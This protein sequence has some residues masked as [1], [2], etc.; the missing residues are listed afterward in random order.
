MPA[1]RSMFNSVD[2]PT[3]GIPRTSTFNSMACGYRVPMS[4]KSSRRLEMNVRR[5]IRGVERKLMT[6]LLKHP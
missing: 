4:I 3:L 1:C 5:S 2:F 6:Y